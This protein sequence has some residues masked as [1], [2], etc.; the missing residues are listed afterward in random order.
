M[1]EA[2]V[3]VLPDFEKIFEVGCDASNVGIFNIKSVIAGLSFFSLSF[4]LKHKAGKL[5][6]VADA[7]VRR[8]CLLQTMEAKKLVI[9]SSTLFEGR[10]YSRDTRRGLAGHF[11]RDKT[12]TVV[13]EKFFWPKMGQDVKRLVTRRVTCHKAKSHGTNAGLYTPLPIPNSPW[14]DVSMDFVLGLPRSQRNKDSVRLLS[15]DYLRWHILFHVTKPCMPLMWQT[16]ILEK[17]P[18]FMAFQKQS[19]Q[20]RDV[21]FMS[22]FWRTLWRKLG[23]KLQFSTTCHL[24]IDVQTEVVNR[25]LGNILKR[26]IEKNIREWD[27]QLAHAEF[28]YNNSISQTTGRSPFE[29]VFGLNLITPLDLTPIETKYLLSGDAEERIKFIKKLH[30]EVKKNYVAK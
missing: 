19:H 9:C 6:K 22:H 7:L 14:E 3:L 11:G 8:H 17:L 20:D 12:L 15:I 27:L 21:K 26:L 23:T 18:S 25:N 13:Q 1:A 16:F 5:N 30:E 29:V 24:Q 10:N 2:P 4:S 28:A